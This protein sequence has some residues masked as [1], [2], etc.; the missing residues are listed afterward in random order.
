MN[1]FGKRV[2]FLGAHPDDIELGCG[3]LLH[4]IVNQT[5]V[6]CVTLSDNQKNPQLKK[7]VGELYSSMAILGVPK[8]KVVVE[9][10]TTRKF[11]DMRQEILE[12]LLELR[13]DFKPEIVFT[14][15]RQDV[16]QDHNVVTEEA[17]RAYRGIT[18]LGYDVV[19]SSYG[20]FPHFLV[21]VTAEDVE[22]KVEALSQY[23]TYH[24][25]YYFD[26]D[27]LRATM[28]RHGALAER[29]F[30]EGFDILRIVGKFE[31]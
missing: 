9:E 14:H 3:A 15:T 2:L 31:K 11:P 19:R 27:L 1:F 25:K 20:F 22:K 10:F 5:D 12:Y 8:E 29:P 26:T 17:L 6:L 23:E 28:V 18:L 7:V 30:A 21:E 4:H 16:H 24:D 13:R